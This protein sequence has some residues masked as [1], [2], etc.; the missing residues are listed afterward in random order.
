MDKNFII[1][2]FIIVICIIIFILYNKK[3]ESFMPWDFNN[4][5]ENKPNFVK[6]YEN[7]DFQKDPNYKYENI[8]EYNFKRLFHKLKS[9]K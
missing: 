3:K 4:K 2:I 1:Y 5:N 7:I 8:T 9:I 6:N